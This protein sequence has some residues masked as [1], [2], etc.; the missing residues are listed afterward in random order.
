MSTGT[1]RR[2]RGRHLMRP[3]PRR[4]AWWSRVSPGRR[5]AAGRSARPRRCCRRLGRA[6]P[7]PARGAPQPSRKGRA[8]RGDDGGNTTAGPPRPARLPVGMTPRADSKACQSRSSA[9]ISGILPWARSQASTAARSNRGLL[10]VP[11]TGLGKSSWRRRQLLT[12]LGRTPAMR[13]MSA[14]D[15]ST[16]FTDRRLPSRQHLA[17]PEHQLYGVVT[18]PVHVHTPWF[19][20]SILVGRHSSHSDACTLVRGGPE[21]AVPLVTSCHL[22][23]ELPCP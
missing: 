17:S 6:R 16:C 14:A 19:S 1:R 13:A 11:L 3:V 23:E 22:P 4:A 12:A 5:G 21:I 2:G 7:R 15:T 9:V 20:L 10:S 8:F 18:S